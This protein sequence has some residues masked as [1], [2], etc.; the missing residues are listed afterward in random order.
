MK[1]I[2]TCSDGTWNRPGI[3]DRGKPV[4]SNVEL[5][6]NSI[7]STRSANVIIPQIKFYETGVGSSS[8]EIKDQIL[9]GAEGLG[10]DKK[11]KDLYTFLLLN[12]EI[13]DEL[14]FFGFSRGAYTARSLAGMVRNCG[15]LK[16]ENIALLDKAYE[17]Y[18]DKNDYTS[19]DSDLMKSFRF[20]YSQEDITPIKFIGV[21]DTVGSLGL[22]INKKYNLEKYKFHDVKLSSY[23]QNAYH[24][25]SIDEKRSLFQPALWEMSPKNIGKQNLEQRWFIGVHC[26]VGGGYIDTK[27]SDITL[28]WM[29]EKA[30]DVGLEFDD[31]QKLNAPNYTFSPHYNGELRNSRSLIYRIFPAIKRTYHLANNRKDAN[32]ELLLTN[33]S[34]D[35]SVTARVNDPLMNYKI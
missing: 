11:I 17:M 18:R 8:Y 19:P 25:L 32:G 9:G 35:E 10:I 21:W 28:Q 22:P 29:G 5:F 23:V 31:F 1:R 2:I 24:A 6:Y 16:P 15:I 27:L 26:N 7:V 13:G 30:K 12:Y 14:Y 34:I 33:E 3:T 20:Q 4:K